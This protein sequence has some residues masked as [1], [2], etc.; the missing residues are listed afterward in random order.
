MHLNQWAI[1]MSWFCKSAEKPQEIITVIPWASSDPSGCLI[2]SLFE[3]SCASDSSVFFSSDLLIE[4]FLESDWSSSCDFLLPYRDK[5]PGRW[6]RSPNL[7]SWK[8]PT[9]ESR[10]GL[11]RAS[12][13]PIAER[14]WLP[15][16]ARQRGIWTLG[17]TWH[18]VSSSP[19]TSSMS[20][21]CK[22]SCNDRYRCNLISKESFG[23]HVGAR[24]GIQQLLLVIR[25]NHRLSKVQFQCGWSCCYTHCMRRAKLL[26]SYSSV[27]QRRFT[28]TN[29]TS[30]HYSA[31]IVHNKSKLHEFSKLAHTCNWGTARGRS[32]ALHIQRAGSWWRELELLL[33][34]R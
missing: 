31:C 20:C 33:Q 23:K 7:D 15:C 29:T 11:S 1:H 19:F 6:N 8:L 34:W 5:D 4:F 22:V 17:V 10:A 27:C 9:G 14:L 2:V 13:T 24:E 12:H 3:S 18:F 26:L 32:R 16:V 21:M 25:L 30:L 28:K